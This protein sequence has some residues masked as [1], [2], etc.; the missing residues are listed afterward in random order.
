[1]E[2]LREHTQDPIVLELAKKIPS[3]GSFGP[4]CGL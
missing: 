4:A 1:M 2:E 3:E